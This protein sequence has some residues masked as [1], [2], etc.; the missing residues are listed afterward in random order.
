MS[1]S[2]S[3]SELSSLDFIIMSSDETLRKILIDDCVLIDFEL[4]DEYNENARS[5]LSVVPFVPVDVF[6]CVFNSFREKSTG[7][8]IIYCFSFTNGNGNFLRNNAFI[9][10][11]VIRLA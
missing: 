7:S 1:T 5:E 10:L 2:L 4:I 9:T 8:E 3:S 11:S 6:N